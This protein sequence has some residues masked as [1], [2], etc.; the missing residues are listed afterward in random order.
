MESVL[1]SGGQLLPVLFCE[2]VIKEVVIFS[3]KIDTTEEIIRLKSHL[4][5][6]FQTL[7]SSEKAIGRK[8]DFIIQEMNR[9]VNSLSVKC[10]DLEIVKQ[11][12]EIKSEIE[13]VREQ[14]QNIE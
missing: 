10:H 14:V 4:K 3:E 1:P 13:K 11:S 7:N 2:K 8:L 5:Q 6:F 12:L 9:E